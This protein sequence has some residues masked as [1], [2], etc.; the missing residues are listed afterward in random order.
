M[1]SDSSQQRIAELERRLEEALREIAALREENARLRKELEEWKRGFRERRK[2]R[3]SR[4]ERKRKS[5]GKKP[6]RKAG[7]AGAQRQV[8][9]RIDRHVE[10]SMPGCCP[11]CGGT[12]IEPTGERDEVVVQDIPEPQPVENVKHTAEVGCCADCGARVATRLPGSTAS[13]HSVAKVVLGPNVLAM[14]LGLRF[15]YRAPLQGICGFVGQ[16][17]GLSLTA[18]GLSQAFGRWADWSGSSYDEIVEHVRAAPLVGAD[19]TGLRQDGLSGYA[20]LARTDKASL[21]RIELS[22]GSWVIEQMLGRRFVGVVSS[23]FY[24]VYTRRDDWTHAYCGAHV[25]REAKKI[26]EVNPQPSTEWFRDRLDLLYAD[27]KQ[28]QQSGDWSARHGIR[29]RF[30]QFVAQPHV[31]EHPDVTRLRQRL[32]EHFYGV[33]TFVDR[34]DVPADNNATE[35]DIRPL[36][37]YRKVTG[38]T[39]SPRGSKTL[40][41]WMSVTQTL[42]KNGLNLRDFVVDLYAH[43]YGNSPPPSVFAPD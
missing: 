16:W 39:R 29:V 40:A 32:D 41:H 19:E 20:W 7:H 15:D 6:G 11:D 22:R 31:D 21:F 8:P 36:A 37:V 42:H 2:R 3:T 38:G 34:P 24:S 35:R 25:Q 13:G 26:A 9:D 4:S 23:D 17:Y 33:L 14:A 18:G 10:H 1:A 28:A 30:G 27:A 5:G 12:H 43:H